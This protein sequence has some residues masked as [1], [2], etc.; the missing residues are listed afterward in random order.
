[1][2]QEN[3]TVLTQAQ[4]R[5]MQGASLYAPTTISVNGDVS[6]ATVAMVRRMLE[7]RDARLARSMQHGRMRAA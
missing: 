7:E 6:P 1:M 2:P 3:G 5:Q 4:L